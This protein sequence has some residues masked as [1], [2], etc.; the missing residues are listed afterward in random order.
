MWNQGPVLGGS[1][2]LKLNA[3]DLF[4]IYDVAVGAHWSAA[5]SETH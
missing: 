4:A 2:A 5:L 3:G 1:Q